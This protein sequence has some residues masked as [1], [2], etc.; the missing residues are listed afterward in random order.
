MQDNHQEPIIVPSEE[1]VESE[2][3]RIRYRK[4][5]FRTLLNTVAVLIVV[6]AA[7]VLVSTIFMPVIQVSGDSMSPT[8]ND[9]DILVTFNTDHIEYGDLCC[10]SWQNKMLL[11]R[12]IGLP[13][14]TVS[15]REDG[16]VYV[17]GT[18][19]DE[20]Y[21]IEKSIGDCEI[22]FPYAVPDNQIFILGDNRIRSVDSRNK[23]IGS[24]TKEQIIGKVLFR[25]WPLGSS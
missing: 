4:K 17:N 2:L 19:L 8:L 10:V 6:A 5:F 14:D 25:I 24:I 7:A 20:P 3:N 11:K 15:I 21:V 22:S 23:D 16:S 9:G 18:L 12:V 13:G 1:Q